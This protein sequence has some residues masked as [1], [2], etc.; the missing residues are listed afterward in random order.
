MRAPLL[1]GANTDEGTS[2]GINYGPNGTGVNSDSEWL[3]VLNSTGIAPS[4]QTAAILN[5]LYPNIQ[6]LGIPN[7]ATFPYIIPPS[8]NFSLQLGSQFRRLTS[9]FGDV[10]VHAPRRATSLAWSAF[11]VPSYAYR[12]DVV[13]NGIATAVGSTHFQE[14]AFVFNNIEGLGYAT[15]PFGNMSESDNEKFNNLS[16]LMCRSWISF[17]ADGDPNNHGIENVPSWPLYNSSEGGGMGIN[18]VYTVN[19]TNSSY[20]EWDNWRGEGIAF[21]MENAL[22]VYGL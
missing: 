8:S 13:V 4:S 22:S 14:V 20:I 15:N 16:T 11:Q 1:I 21:L 5:Y 17:I 19:V 18:M 12:F 9:Y 6:G 7:L 3:D 2:F 10:V